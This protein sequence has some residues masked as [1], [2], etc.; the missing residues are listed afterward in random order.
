[1]SEINL[2]T[3]N[4]IKHISA[5]LQAGSDSLIRYLCETNIIKNIGIAQLL[6]LSERRKYM[7]ARE[8]EDSVLC[9]MKQNGNELES[10]DM[11]TNS[12]WN[13]MRRQF[14]VNP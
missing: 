12:V 2:S 9:L 13:R 6:Q 3:K 11:E 10:Y 8:L 14:G 7:S 4:G 5:V 1:M